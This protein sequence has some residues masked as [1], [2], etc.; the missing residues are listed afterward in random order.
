MVQASTSDIDFTAL[1][2]IDFHNSGCYIYYS[3][4]VP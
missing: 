1:E 3:V 4:S 2:Y